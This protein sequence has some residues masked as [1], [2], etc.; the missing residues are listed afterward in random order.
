MDPT[1][2]FQAI[3]EFNKFLN[4]P[5]GQKLAEANNEL[6]ARLLDKLGF[7]LAVNEPPKP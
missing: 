2:I 4:S 7:H 1:A 3:A 6:V 5:P